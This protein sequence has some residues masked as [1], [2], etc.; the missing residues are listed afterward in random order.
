M[1]RPCLLGTAEIKTAKRARGGSFHASVTGETSCTVSTREDTRLRYD[2]AAALLSAR[3]PVVALENFDYV[4][5]L[6]QACRRSAA[7]A[8]SPS[9]CF[10]FAP[11]FYRRERTRSVPR[12]AKPV[13]R[14]HGHSWVPHRG[15]A[16]RARPSHGRERA[17]LVSVS[18][19]AAGER[20]SR[21]CKTEGGLAEDN[22]GSGPCEHLLPLAGPTRSPTRSLLSAS[23]LDA[24]LK[25]LPVA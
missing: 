4:S 7:A 12:A 2:C 6:L 21:P 10:F 8:L 20:R 9:S 24:T 17:V 22:A 13:T 19:A 16:P 15:H 1:R 18:H 25:A 14:N 3:L 11:R 23:C 5:S